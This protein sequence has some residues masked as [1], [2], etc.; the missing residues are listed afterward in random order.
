MGITIEHITGIAT[1]I[2]TGNATRLITE[3]ILKTRAG[4]RVGNIIGIWRILYQITK[5]L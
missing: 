2:I 5:Q 4:L 1:E 3:T